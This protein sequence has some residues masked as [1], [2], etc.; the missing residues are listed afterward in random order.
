MLDVENTSDAHQ[1]LR[2]EGRVL[3]VVGDVPNHLLEHSLFR[4]SAVGLEGSHALLE[5]VCLPGNLSEE[6]RHVAGR[7]TVGIGS[8][9]S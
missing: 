6:A 5:E 2:A 3:D 4:A 1:C 8:R 9:E 7:L